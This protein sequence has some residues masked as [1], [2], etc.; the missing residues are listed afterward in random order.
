MDPAAAS[1]CCPHRLRSQN[2]ADL[3]PLCLSAAALAA[4]DASLLQKKKAPVHPGAFSFHASHT[5]M[6][7]LMWALF[8]ASFTMTVA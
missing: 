4:R 6:R 2:N 5:E 3:C 8:S 7:S 1:K